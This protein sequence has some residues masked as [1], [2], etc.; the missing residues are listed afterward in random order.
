MNE[1][2]EDSVIERFAIR[3]PLPFG[4]FLAVS[5]Y[6]TSG[7]YLVFDTLGIQMARFWVNRPALA[8]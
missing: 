8:L 5:V 6:R 2:G 7:G 4:F 3:M 1:S